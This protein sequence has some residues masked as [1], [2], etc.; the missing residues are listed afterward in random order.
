M[1]GSVPFTGSIAEED[2]Y[3]LNS[4][5]FPLGMAMDHSAQLGAFGI[6]LCGVSVGGF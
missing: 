2:R 4:P 5:L 1:Y 6:V 3:E